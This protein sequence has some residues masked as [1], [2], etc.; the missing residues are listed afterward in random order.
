MVRQYLV[1]STITS[2]I[3]SCMEMKGTVPKMFVHL[4]FKVYLYGTSKTI[5]LHV[6]PKQKISFL[7]L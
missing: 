3:L 4:G 1:Y 7:V 2:S 6:V 5:K